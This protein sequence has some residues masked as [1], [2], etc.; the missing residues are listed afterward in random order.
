MSNG[1]GAAGT[2]FAASAAGPA[3]VFASVAVGGAFVAGSGG[4]G[5]L[6]AATVRC[7]IGAAG[8]FAVELLGTDR[9]PTFIGGG[10]DATPGLTAA[11]E[12]GGNPLGVDDAVS[13]EVA[14]AV[15]IEV[16]GAVEFVFG[17]LAGP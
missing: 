11:P 8:T 5:D 10:F 6:D 4:G 3:A 12:F 1:A 16:G 9:A 13:G 7:S 2:S 14:E 15:D 17:A